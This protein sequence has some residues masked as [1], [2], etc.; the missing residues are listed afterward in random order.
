MREHLKKRTMVS[1]FT[2]RSVGWILDFERSQAF[3]NVL[4]V[5]DKRGLRRSTLQRNRPEATV[6]SD[7][8]THSSAKTP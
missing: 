4:C 2:G 7:P 1:L 6:R 8:G 3:A 5:E